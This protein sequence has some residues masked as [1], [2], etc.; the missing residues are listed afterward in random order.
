MKYINSSKLENLKLNKD[1]TYIVIDFDRTITSR[2]SSDSWSISG[3]L[4]GEEFEKEINNLYQKYRPI[5]IDYKIPKNEKQEAMNIWYTQC[6]DLYHKYQLTKEK[7][8]QS[9][10]AG[11]LIYRKG[12]KEFLRESCKRKNTNY[13]IICWN[14]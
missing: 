12:A 3:C 14:W 13:H 5:E 9:V 7:L 11:G 10:K 4:L 6:M 2:E 1:N 8:E